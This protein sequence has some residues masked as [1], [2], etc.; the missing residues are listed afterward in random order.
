MKN[1]LLKNK[2]W[3]SKSINSYQIKNYDPNTTAPAP[4]L[5]IGNGGGGGKFF[6]SKKKNN[7]NKFK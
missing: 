5:T 6:N 7:I 4:S 3:E 2:R 1:S